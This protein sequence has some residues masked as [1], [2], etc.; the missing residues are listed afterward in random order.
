MKTINGIL[1]ISL[2]CIAYVSTLKLRQVPDEEQPVRRVCKR[3]GTNNNPDDPCKKYFSDLFTDELGNCYIDL[4]GDLNESTYINSRKAW[5]PQ[6]SDIHTKWSKIRVDPQ[7]LKVHTGDF[8]YAT[9]TGHVSHHSDI[10][11]G[12]WEPYGTGADC[13]G[14]ESSTG[15]A[16]VDLRGTKWALED[17]QFTWGGY[18]P[19]SPSSGVTAKDEHNQFWEVRGGGYCGWVTAVGAQDEG[20]AHQGGWFL[21]LKRLEP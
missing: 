12:E 7:T 1:L 21:Q 9:S 11:N 8:K 10:N 18:V 3:K 16:I 17:S 6:D 19:Y 15:Y 5:G 4:Q 13:E 2:C 14:G 20:Q